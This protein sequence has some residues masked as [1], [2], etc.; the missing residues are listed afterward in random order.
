MS[1]NSYNII[2]NAVLAWLPEQPVGWV[3][4]DGDTIAATGSGECPFADYPADAVRTDAG[5]AMLLP[6]LIDTHVHFREPG[7]THKGDIATES[8]AAVLGGI[9]SYI[10]MPNTNPATTTAEAFGQKMKLADGRSRANY[11]F[12]LGASDGIL[13]ALGQI[14]PARL[15]AVKL[16]MGNTTGGMAAPAGDRL[17]AMMRYCADHNIPV[18]VHAEDNAIIAGNTRKA[19]EKYGSAEAV[20]LA[21]HSKIRSAEAC[22]SSARSAV[23]LAREH[24]TRLHLA[25]VSTTPEVDELLAAGPVCGKQITAETT[26][27]YLD[28]EFCHDG[29]RTWRHKIN[30]AIKNFAPGLVQALKDDL[31]DTLA[32]DHA[33]HLVAEKQGGALKAASGAPSVQFALPVMLEYLGPALIARKMAAAPAQ[34]FGIERRG[35][36]APGYAADLVLVEKCTPYT[37]DDTMVQAPCLWTPFH[38]RRVSHRV[39]AVWVNGHMA[40]AE[41][42]LTSSIAGEALTFNHSL[43]TTSR[44]D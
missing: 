31:I 38:G 43:C 12:M 26:P 2:H 33:P 9:T 36:V 34:L 7:L 35:S 42:T 15:P 13:A 23:A 27:L 8:G 18:V 40:V 11:G 16:F 22:L 25:H 10:E 21:E 24:G 5:G 32:T 39:R 28:P 41:G 3:A 30:P 37:I 4:V 19:I 44:N 29:N 1:A 20:P 6:G 14:D 17:A